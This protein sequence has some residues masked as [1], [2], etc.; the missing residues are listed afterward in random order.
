[1]GESD[2]A[3]VRWD[4]SP[5]ETP[6]GGDVASGRVIVSG[7]E[8]LTAKIHE[9]IEATRAVDISWTK[10]GLLMLGIAIAIMAAAV[11]NR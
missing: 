3:S 7:Q 1:M 8:I 5:D 4:A 6:S 10:L 11:L 9:R 2:P